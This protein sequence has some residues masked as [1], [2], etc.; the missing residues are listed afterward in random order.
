MAGLRF[1]K[2][3]FY[4]RVRYSNN[5]RYSEKLVPLRT[6]SKVE[7]RV[8]LNQVKKVEADLKS[9][10]DYSFPWMNAE[11]ELNVK[12]ISIQDC[13]D[14]YLKYLKGN[15]CREA[16]IQRAYYCLRNFTTVLGK[17][18]PIENISSADIGYSGL[19]VQ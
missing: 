13:I 1:L 12:I 11:G 10:I 18:F 8:R 9:S 6:D 19:F 17:G 3:K 16:T 7:A 5:G 2:G 14:E 4:A 15:G